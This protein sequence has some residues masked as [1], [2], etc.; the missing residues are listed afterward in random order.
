MKSKLLQLLPSGFVQ[1][2]HH[3]RLE[4]GPLRRHYAA[5]KN[6]KSY[7]EAISDECLKNINSLTQWR[8]T[9][10]GLQASLVEMLGLNILNQATIAEINVKNILELPNYFVEK[11]VA[12]SPYGHFITANLYLP[13]KATNQVPCIIYLCGHMAHPA[14]AK[15]QYQDRYLWYPNNGIACLVIDP[16]GFGEVAG[17]HH[18]T[19][20]LGWWEWLSMGYTPAGLEVWNAMR[21]VD[22]LQSRLEIDNKRIGVTGISGGGIMAFF[23]GALDDRLCVV[24]PSCSAYT[25]GSQAKLG[26]VSRQC[27]CTFY[28]NFHRLDFSAV[29]ALIAPRP[30]LITCGQKDRLFPPLGYRQFYGCVKRIYDLYAGKEESEDGLIRL[31][32]SSAGHEDTPL[33][34]LEVRKWMSKWLDGRTEKSRVE[35]SV[36]I[37]ELEPEQLICGVSEEPLANYDFPG[38]LFSTRNAV[39]PTTPS[40]WKERRKFLIDQLQQTTFNWF[41]RITATNITRSIRAEPGY[42]KNYSSLEELEIETEPGVFVRTCEFYPKTSSSLIT[43]TMFVIRLDGRN[44]GAEEFLP[45]LANA[46]IIVIHP[47]FSEVTL[48]VEKHSEVERT[49]MISGRTIAAMQIWDVWQV[50]RHKLK[51]IPIQSTIHIYGREIAGIMALYVA[52]LE[53]RVNHLIL[54][55]YLLSH[56]FGCALLGVMRYTDINEMV[57]TIAPR[58]LTIIPTGYGESD[59]AQYI[60]RLLNASSR[61]RFAGSLSEAYIKHG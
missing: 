56:Q 60:Y 61:F 31:V 12:K 15:T 45:L 17:I 20:E 39:Y 34:L 40:V 1:W 24:A 51:D 9:R 2:V 26:L 49:S 46:K 50:I 55:D 22:W 19:Q 48:S 29:A 21:M 42:S 41:S 16:H 13:K 36:S 25:I 4:A 14:G 59:F 54:K 44:Q 7:A 6:V 23:L 5:C 35:N 37:R 52:L 43:Q 28:P 47:R 32:E 8:E 11:V 3:K 33:I 57:A 18:G 53:N 38:R 27:D 10:T 30:L 58:S